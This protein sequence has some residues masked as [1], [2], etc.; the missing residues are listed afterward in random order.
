MKYR[1]IIVCDLHFQC[2]LYKQVRNIVGTA[3]FKEETP[4]KYSES[5]CCLRKVT[6]V[7]KV[8]RTLSA[9]LDFVLDLVYLFLF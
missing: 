7:Y 3:S 2:A 6:E 4:D 8:R 9:T 1:D 5:V